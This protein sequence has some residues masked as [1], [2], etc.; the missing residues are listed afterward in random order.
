MKTIILARVSTEEKKRRVEAGPE[1]PWPPGLKMT[2][3]AGY[4]PHMYRQ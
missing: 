4:A 2:A 3:E 1:R